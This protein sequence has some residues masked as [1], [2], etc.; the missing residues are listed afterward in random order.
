M[1]QAECAPITGAGTITSGKLQDSAALSSGKGNALS[2][3]A[4]MAAA[5]VIP[6][7]AG[8]SV[9]LAKGR[10]PAVLAWHDWR[11]AKLD[12]AAHDGEDEGFD[13]ICRAEETLMLATPVTVAGAIA[14][15]RCVLTFVTDEIGWAKAMAMGMPYP[16]DDRGRALDSIEARTLAGVIEFLEARA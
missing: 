3:R 7:V 2:R 16:R 1:S 14:Q 8:A 9:A 10:D 15:L 5:L 4:I 12:Y 13:D 6:A 11:D